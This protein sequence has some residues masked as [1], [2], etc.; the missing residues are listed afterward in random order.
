MESKGP[1][2]DKGDP[3]SALSNVVY[4]NSNNSIQFE[5]ESGQNPR[6]IR[7]KNS[8]VIQN[9]SLNRY[10]TTNQTKSSKLNRINFVKI[11]IL[12]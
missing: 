12:H 3:G 2:G 5:Y 8:G 10:P 11:K 6:T 7:F 1:T 9:M 4:N